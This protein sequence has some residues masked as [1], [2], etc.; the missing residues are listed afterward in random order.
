MNILYKK[1]NRIFKKKI[2]INDRKNIV[3]FI[4][5][6]SSETSDITRNSELYF[7]SK[8]IH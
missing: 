5:L 7:M 6:Q 1:Q 2:K 8:V 4:N 3:Y